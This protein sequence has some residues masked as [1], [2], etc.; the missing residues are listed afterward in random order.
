MPTLIGQFSDLLG[1]LK[2]SWE[3]PLDLL[4]YSCNVLVSEKRCPG[5]QASGVRRLWECQARIALRAKNNLVTIAYR[6]HPLVSTGTKV[7]FS[8]PPFTSEASFFVFEHSLNGCL[9]E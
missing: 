1:S 9:S 7:A 3:S 6:I 2:S 5:Q 4:G 8:S